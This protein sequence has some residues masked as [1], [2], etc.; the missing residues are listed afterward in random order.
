MD[1]VVG[2][3]RVAIFAM[4]HSMTSSIELYPQLRFPLDWNHQVFT[5]QMGNGPMVSLSC[6]GRMAISLFGMP[7]ALTLAPLYI[8]S[9]TSNAGTVA[10][11]AEEKLTLYGNLVPS[12]FFVSIAFETSGV[13]GPKSRLF[14]KELGHRLKLSTGE[15]R[16]AAFLLQRLSVAVQRGNAA[17]VLGSISFSEDL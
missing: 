4:L 2:G 3:V 10:A 6:L 15:A 17:S 8:A 7:P 13:I 1:S 12:H 11:L 14:L 16:S 9:D 5:E